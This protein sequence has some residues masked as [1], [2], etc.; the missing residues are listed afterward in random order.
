MITSLIAA[1]AISAVL[2]S[3]AVVAIPARHVHKA[4]SC[5]IKSRLFLTK[6]LVHV[7][8]WYLHKSAKFDGSFPF[9][10]HHVLV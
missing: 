10:I 9:V 2:R 3:L 5:K 6:Y 4:G 7:F 1:Y 8:V